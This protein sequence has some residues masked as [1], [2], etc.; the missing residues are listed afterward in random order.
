MLLSTVVAVQLF[1]S[2]L[3]LFLT[4]MVF[5][6]LKLR[7]INSS[8]KTACLR[9]LSSQFI[10]KK[11]SCETTTIL[12]FFYGVSISLLPDHEALLPSV[13][14]RVPPPISGRCVQWL[15]LSS[16][17]TSSMPFPV[18]HDLNQKNAIVRARQ[19]H[20]RR[21]AHDC[22]N[23]RSRKRSHAGT[24]PNPPDS[25]V[26]SQRSIRENRSAAFRLQ[27]SR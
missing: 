4:T 3:A 18:C 23:S 17:N 2:Q 20:R 27:K 26:P 19:F 15:G 24:Q 9:V 6:L 16:P 12:A 25:F 7:I 8:P 5:L 10:T 1:T 11:L 13:I 14:L 21:T 22:D